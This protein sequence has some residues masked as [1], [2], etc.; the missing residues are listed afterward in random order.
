MHD[1]TTPFPPENGESLKFKVGDKVTF[2][3]EYGVK[4]YG[5]IV[6][7]IMSRADDEAQYC[8]GKRYYINTDCHWMPV[9][10]S[11]LIPE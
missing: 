7:R 1:A 10:E 9:K 5:R 8:L 3:N 6:T 4:C 11:Q 2:V